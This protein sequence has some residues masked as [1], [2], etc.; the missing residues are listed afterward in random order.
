MKID[1]SISLSKN[2]LIKHVYNLPTDLKKKIY[3]DNFHIKHDCDEL[4]KWLNKNNSLRY[5]A[6]EV[7][8]L[9]NK[10][11]G[12]KEGIEYM[13][14]NNDF[15]EKYYKKHFIDNDLQFILMNNTTSLITCILMS[16]WH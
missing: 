4:I 8:D 15:F 13:K 12:S 14:E 1:P 16:M 9:T 10:I 6:Y 3:C 2:S 5:S 7:E 11:L